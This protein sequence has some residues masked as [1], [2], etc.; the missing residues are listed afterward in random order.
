MQVQIDKQS[1]NTLARILDNMSA[2]TVKL[3]KGIDLKGALEAYLE[4][5]SRGWA[6]TTQ[7]NEASRVRSLLPLLTTHGFDPDKIHTELS[8]ESAPYTVRMKFVRLKGFTDFCI[9]NNLITGLNPFTT[10]MKYT[11]PNKFKM[12]SIYKP[13]VVGLTYIEAKAN[14]N[15]IED[16][17][18]RVTAEFLLKSGLRISE[19]YSLEQSVDGAWFVKGKGGKYRGVMVN[20]PEQLCSKSKL[21]RAL[22]TLNLTPHQLRKLNAT[23]L[24]ASGLNVS[25]LQQVMGWGSLNTA[26]YYLQQGATNTLKTKIG[27]V[28]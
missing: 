4:V 28:L 11:A 24:V 23:H 17:L 6:I 12:S 10:Y 19:L 21:V 9:N 20:P 25:E 2:K 15:S 3:N 22:T 13:K 14:I 1:E 7:E 16:N 8:K 27:D 18:V 5:S 26:Q